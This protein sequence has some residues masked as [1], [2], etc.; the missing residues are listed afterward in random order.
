[1]GLLR[2][3]KGNAGLL[4]SLLLLENMLGTL[5]GEGRGKTRCLQLAHRGEP[6]MLG[7]A[8]GARCWGPALTRMQPGRDTGNKVG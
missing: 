2:K 6:E 5:V 4:F 8:F 7:P 3:E 1:M